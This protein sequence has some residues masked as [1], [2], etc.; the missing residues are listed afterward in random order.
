[1]CLVGS[2]DWLRELFQLGNVVLM[3]VSWPSLSTKVLIV[4]E[5]DQ[6]GLKENRPSEMGCKLCQNGILTKYVEKNQSANQIALVR[7]SSGIVIDS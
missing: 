4:Y 3:M 6:I 7:S 5:R 2:G 1:M